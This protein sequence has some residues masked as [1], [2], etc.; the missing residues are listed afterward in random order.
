[1][2]RTL[3]NRYLLMRHA[4]SRANAEHKIVSDPATGINGYGLTDTGRRQV[5]KAVQQYPE[6]ADVDI[7]YTS[8]FL[9]ARQTAEIVASHAN[10][11][12][13]LTTPLLRERFF[14]D[15]DGMAHANYEKIWD[16]DCREEDT[17]CY[18]VEPIWKLRDRVFTLMELCEKRYSGKNI[19]L[20][21]HGDTLQVL[22][23]V[24]SGFEA[25]Q[26]RKPKEFSNAEVRVLPEEIHFPETGGGVE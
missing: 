4:R 21:A 2:K 22:Y 15:F 12:Y 3:N 14:G 17:S 24:A 10:D 25:P 18:N 23:A 8:D 9:R 26:F 7:I 20:V 6:L 1:M 16:M 5:A 13:M 11:A 19:L